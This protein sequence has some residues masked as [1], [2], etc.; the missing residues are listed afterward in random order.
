MIMPVEENKEL[1]RHVYDLWNR[2]ELADAFDLHDPG[3]CEYYPDRTMQP[4]EF[5]NFVRMFVAAFP[6]IVSMIEDM[7]AENDKVAI[8]VTWRGTHKNQFMGIPATGNKIEITNTAIFRIAGGKL[9]ENW[10]TTDDMRLMRQLG[11]IPKT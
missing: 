4:A 7:V 8:R 2:K 9:A 6:D 1:L 11:V 5:R 10:A 3:Y